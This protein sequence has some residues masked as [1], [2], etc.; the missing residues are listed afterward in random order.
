MG[1]PANAN[2]RTFSNCDVTAPPR[3]TKG[4]CGDDNSG[5]KNW[6]FFFYSADRIVTD[7]HQFVRLFPQ[8]E[9]SAGSDPIEAKSNY[10]TEQPQCAASRHGNEL[11]FSETF[12][13]IHQYGFDPSAALPAY[14]GLPLAQTH[15]KIRADHSVRIGV[16]G[17]N[18]PSLAVAHHIA[19]AST[20]G[21]LSLP[22]AAE[23][24]VTNTTARRR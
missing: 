1:K 16:G 11:T 18:V 19:S 14:P 20:G 9:G 5:V 10:T 13:D 4:S 6:V 21:R 17:P 12:T 3:E 8:F 15:S 22:D 24:R 23:T 7:V 2:T